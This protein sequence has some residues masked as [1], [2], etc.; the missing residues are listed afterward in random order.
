L[1]MHQAKDHGRDRWEFFDDQVGHEARQRVFIEA[2][3]RE[4]L[5]DGQFVPWFQPIV[6]L[7]DGVVVGYE[8]LV[9]WVRPSGTVI[10]P[11]DFLG[12]AEITSLISEI[13][14]AV[15]PQ[16]LEV[17][18]KLPSSVTMAINISAATLASSDYAAQV[19]DSLLRSGVDADRL[20]IEFTETA[21]LNVSDQVHAVMDLL[22]GAG[23]RWYVDDFGTGF[24]SI[25]HLR[26]LP[27]AG[28][29]LDMSFTHGLGGE[30]Q[31]SDRLAQALSA[32]ANSLELD[33]VAEGV[34]TPE[35]AA[36]L[37]AQGWRHGQG[38]LYG[39]PEPA[40]AILP[41]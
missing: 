22:A 40:S 16:S 18:A 31:T 24:S 8:A 20:H 6:N 28:L 14:L 36:I 5:A 29:K 23:V 12:V 39:H 19:A 25:S 11:D 26:D 41:P 35:Q 1:A 30:D 9:R 37:K 33:T 4:G 2:R 15:L 32:L 7:D 10:A 27:I 34:E 38:W 13:D 17:A 21:L 3:I